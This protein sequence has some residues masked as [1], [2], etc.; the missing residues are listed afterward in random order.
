MPKA[1][2]NGVALHYQYRS[3]NGPTI[4]LVH[5]LATNLAFWYFKVAPLFPSAYS[6]IVYDL[7]GHGQ[8]E[9]PPS[10][11]TTAELAT[12]L[13]GL[14]D[15]LE[16]RQAHLVGHSYGGAVALHCAV[17]HPER[18]A[19]LVLADARI[20]ALQ[21]TQC[22][23]DWPNAARWE[24]KL[25]EFGTLAS[26]ED[27]E[28]GCRLL[29]ILAAAKVQKREWQAGL[30][31]A[32]S[33]F[34]TSSSSRTAQRWLHL[35]QTTTARSD[36]SNPAGLTMD[37]ID[38]VNRPVLAAFGELSHCLQSC[39]GLKQHLP[40]CEVVIVPRAGHFHPVVRPAL[41]EHHV[42]RFVGEVERSM[43]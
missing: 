14:L 15:H 36:F 9:M 25:K 7:R 20:R 35:L 13:H 39:W 43:N 30:D 1:I 34:G 37:H 3:G 28:M 29:E 18:V 42:R 16:V 10:G 33:P 19:S 24:K 23:K 8:S 12:D 26:L 31:D 6:L 5:G 11:Y 32:F 4:F 21:P 27:P 38:R 22:L 2:I 41:F 40:Q 17:L